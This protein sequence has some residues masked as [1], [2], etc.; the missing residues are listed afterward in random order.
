MSE[1]MGGAS[2]SS[3]IRIDASDMLPDFDSDT[4]MP[5]GKQIMIAAKVEVQVPAKSAC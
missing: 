2:R 1:P 5:V 3:A 4:S